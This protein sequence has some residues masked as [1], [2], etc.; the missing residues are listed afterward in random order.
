MGLQSLSVKLHLGDG[1][2]FVRSFVSVVSVTGVHP[3]GE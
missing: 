2:T 1:R 3:M